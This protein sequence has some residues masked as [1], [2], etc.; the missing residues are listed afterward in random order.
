MS[1]KFPG[2]TNKP[3]FFLTFCEQTAFFK[4][5]D[6]FPECFFHRKDNQVEPMFCM[7]GNCPVN[8]N[9]MQAL[10]QRVYVLFEEVLP[11]ADLLILYYRK[12]NLPHSIGGTLFWRDMREPRNI[13]IN[14][15]GWTNIKRRGQ[16]YQFHPPVS[17][18]ITGRAEMPQE[19]QAVENLALD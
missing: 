14:P 11:R 15:Y 1:L 10:S 9:C 13:T 6:I 19:T 5:E 4:L 7:Q 16:V 8:K 3:I 12:R 17:F 2:G 18:F